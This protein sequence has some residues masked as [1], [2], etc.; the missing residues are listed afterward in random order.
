MKKQKKGKRRHNSANRKSLLSTLDFCLAVCLEKVEGAGEDSFLYHV[1]DDMALAGVFDGCGGAGARRYRAFRGKTGAYLAARIVCGSVRDCLLTGVFRQETAKA[2][3]QIRTC[4]YENLK[5]AADLSGGGSVLKSG[6]MK[7]LPTTMALFT[8]REQEGRLKTDCFWAGDSRCYCLDAGGLHQ[9]TRDDLD[10]L[11]ALENL[12]ADGVM[13]NLISLSA[14]FV[15]H[16]AELLL[17]TP[18]IL[19][20]ASD[21]VF[22]Y[23]ATP[24]EFELHLLEAL[25][26]ADSVNEWEAGFEREL[27]KVAGD[28][29]TLTGAAFGFEQFSGLK[30]AF[31][32]RLAV[33]RSEYPGLEEMDDDGK[34]RLWETYRTDYEVWLNY[35][36]PAGG[37]AGKMGSAKITDGCVIGTD[38]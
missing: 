19:F 29:A 12:T 23:Y 15:I 36:N 32:K 18:A 17:E 7:E 30:E 35:P 16:T 27:A 22:A 21:G 31:A 3:G 38:Q 13:T 20:A 28:D 14:D 37:S 24:M 2:A 6:L 26:A 33:L 5:L 9:L 8:C 34:R 10:D 11:N 25:E 4:I 1:N